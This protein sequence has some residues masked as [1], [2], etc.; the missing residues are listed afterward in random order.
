MKTNFI[1][2]CLV[3]VFAAT[4]LFAK[5]TDPKNAVAYNAL[6]TDYISCHMNSDAKKLSRILCDDASFKIPRGENLILQNKANLVDQMR[7]EAG[8]QQNCESNYQL[9]AES[10]AM[11]IAK[12]DFTYGS[13]TQTNF[14][15][16]EKNADK[17]WKITQVCKFFNDVQK[18]DS[19]VTANAPM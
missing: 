12:V 7:K 8:I 15:V 13:S 2:L 19:P 6:V 4:S 9:L 10:D 3:C 5:T 11:V 18:T 14:L 17:V 16:I 1:M